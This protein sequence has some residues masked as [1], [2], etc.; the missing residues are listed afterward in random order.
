MHKDEKD[1]A[2]I[3][4]LAVVLIILF[5]SISYSIGKGEGRE[6]CLISL[7]IGD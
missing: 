1:S 4:T 6:T 5:S 7:P 3:L 2:I